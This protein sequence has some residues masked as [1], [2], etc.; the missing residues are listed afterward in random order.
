MMDICYENDHGG[1]AHDLM[2]CPACERIEEL[3]KEKKELETKIETLDL[4]RKD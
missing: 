4:G 3:L 2:K 1:I